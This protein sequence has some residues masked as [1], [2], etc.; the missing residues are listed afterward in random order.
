VRILLVE[1]DAETAGYVQQGLNEAGHSV[2][3]APDGR[4]GL[5]RAAGEEW[6]LLIIDRMLPGLDGLGLVRT[7]RGGGIES[8]VLFLTTLGGIDERVA[9]LNAGADDYLVKPFAFSELA[10]RVAALG[11][12]PRRAAPDTRLNVA[13]LE[14][15]LLA[16]TVRRAGHLLDLQPREFRLL[17]FLMRHT[18]QVVTR[19]MLLEQ[20]WDLHFDPHTN[21]VESHISRLRGKIDRGHTASLIHTVRGAGYCLR[22]TP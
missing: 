15:D 16:R 8:P 2:A 10:A 9:G 12:R 21:V 3:I 7:L 5:F 14:M 18:D 17:E 20:V 4:D 1:D 13:D 19:T 11:R 6:D 22:A